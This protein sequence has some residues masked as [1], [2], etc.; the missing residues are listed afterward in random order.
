[1]MKPDEI[2]KKKIAEAEKRILGLIESGD[3]KSI[4]ESEKYKISEFYEV[5]SRN[6]LESARL[7]YNASKNDNTLGFDKNYKDYSE[8]VSA[9]Y[10]SMY[11]IVHA[12]IALSYKRKL[13]EGLR[14]VHA[15]TKHLILHYMV[16]TKKLAKHLYERYL[17]TLET[18]AEI[19]NIS[20][21][22]FEEKAYSY[23]K[24]YDETRT[25]R[26][27]FTYNVTANI[28][29]YRAKQS[30]DIA[31]EFINTLRQLMI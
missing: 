17:E 13:R 31:E 5:K 1:M 22:D 9:A 8:V 27:V 30:I 23:V 18:T 26:E 15:I 4:S 10:Y 2:I 12:F 14:G 7:I 25:N 3:L 21:K 16:K 6:R 29:E 28:E 11:Y 20:I 19:Q 24:K